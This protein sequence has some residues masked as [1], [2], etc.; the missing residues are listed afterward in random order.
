M[1]VD[2]RQEQESTTQRVERILLDA[3]YPKRP[4]PPP[5]R[6]RIIRNLVGWLV[7]LLIPILF[8]QFSQ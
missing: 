1:Q 3:M 4:E 2:E 6:G 7:I 8:I 5:S